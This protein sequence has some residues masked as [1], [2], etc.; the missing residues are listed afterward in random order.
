MSQSNSRDSMV[1]TRLETLQLNF[2]D[3]K[4]ELQECASSQGIDV[5]YHQ[6]KNTKILEGEIKNMEA[7]SPKEEFETINNS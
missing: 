1:I 3:Y 2:E 5:E 7:T 4:K 6:N